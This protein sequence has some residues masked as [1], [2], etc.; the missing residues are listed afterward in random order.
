MH[1]GTFPVREDD[2]VP[3]RH[4]SIGLIS[5]GMKDLPPTSVPPIH[6]TVGSPLEYGYRTKIT[7]HFDAPSE[8]VTEG[9][10]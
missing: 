10:R 3:S 2:S 8:E 9:R 6:T 7:P 4:S 5:N 1:I